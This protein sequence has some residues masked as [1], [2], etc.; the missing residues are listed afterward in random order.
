MTLLDRLDLLMKQ[1]NLNR[2]KLALI[3]G[4]P[5]TTIYGWYTRGFENM[6]LPSLKRLSDCLGCSMEYLVN[7]NELTRKNWND[8]L[9][10][11]Y[12]LAPVP[13]QEN[14]CTLLRIPHVKP[15]TAPSVSNV[16]QRDP[17]AA[18]EMIEML[19]FDHPA[20]AG[21]PVYTDSDFERI[22]FPVDDV[23][24]RADFGI[25]IS[26][27]S[28]SPTIE[29]GQI[30]WVRKQKD[31]RNGE[32]GIFMLGDSAVCKR[33]RIVETSNLVAL[34]SDNRAYDPIAGGDL[35]DARCVG[36]VLL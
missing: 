10:D 7:G 4:I 16:L 27:D 20:A 23:S 1:Q 28:M 17:P 5:K 25:R 22:E 11:A 32:I 34:E 21:C 31:I 13:T 30:V 2:S 12:V 19:I 29:D 35:E 15:G 36:R 8:I 24:Y 9:T 3:T 26:G 18:P 6:T 33:A 14:I